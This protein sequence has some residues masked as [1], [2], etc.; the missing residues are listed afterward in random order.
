MF[1]IYHVYY[2]SRFSI[3]LSRSFCLW[4][5]GRWCTP[6]H[7]THPTAISSSKGVAVGWP[8]LILTP[9]PQ[10]SHRGWTPWTSQSWK[11]WPTSSNR[12][13]SSL[14]SE[15]VKSHLLWSTGCNA[16]QETI[17]L[18]GWPVVKSQAACST[19]PRGKFRYRPNIHP[20]TSHRASTLK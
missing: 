16:G 6:Q 15:L 13:A 14:G 17:V 1:Y 4:H 8:V 18:Q 9:S 11:H 5:A 20:S 12:A 7:G 2:S 3:F 19:L 10:W